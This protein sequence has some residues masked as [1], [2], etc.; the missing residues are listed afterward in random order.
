MT[1]YILVLI[2]TICSACTP[3]TKKA[4]GPEVTV[5]VETPALGDTSRVFSTYEVQ[6]NECR[7]RWQTISTKEETGLNVHL[8]NRTICYLSFK[9][10]SPFHEAILQRI[11][12]DYPV[13]T[14]K[15]LSTGGLRTME[16][17]G[18]WNDI[19]GKAASVS[20][21]WMDYRKNYPKHASRLSS[22]DIFVKLLKSTDAHAPFREM[23]KKVGL[24]ME[25]EGVEKVFN[26]KDEKGKTIIN[27]AG[28]IW[29]KAN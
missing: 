28:I 17:E 7:I 8:Q 11:I 10:A 21:E 19:V 12:K 22:N 14:I 23:L 29:W 25:V 16:P 13:A 4:E 2:L 24:N 27:D 15:S 20:P 5:H 3:E 1:K 26:D 6:H 18:L 9:E